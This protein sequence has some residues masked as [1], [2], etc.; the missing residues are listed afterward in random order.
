MN[1][2][3]RVLLLTMGIMLVLGGKP[4]K[5]NLQNQSPVI[6]PS[7]LAEFS[8][9]EQSRD[10]EEK[11]VTMEQIQNRCL[12]LHGADGV[13]LTV[14]DIVEFILGPGISYSNVSAQGIFG[15][16]SE[17][18][19]G[20]FSNGDCVPL[21]FDEG[22]ILSSG[23]LANVMG[24]NTSSETSA[25][26]GLPG[27]ADLNGLIPGYETYDASWI[28]FDF[29]PDDDQIYIQYVF[30]SEEYNQFVNSEYNDVF[31]FF[32]NGE[33]IALLPG[34]DIPVSINNV[35]NG[36]AVAGETAD[37]PC[38]NCEFYRDNADLSNPVF[39]IECDGMTTL[40]TATSEVTPG[41]TYTIKLAI[42]DAGD[43][44]LDSWVFIKAESFSTEEPAHANVITNDAEQVTNNEALLGGEVTY[45]GNLEV[46]GRGVWYGTSPDPAST[47]TKIPM[48]SGLGSFSD[49]VTNLHPN[50]HYYFIAYAVND[51]GTA[52]GEEK[53]FTTL[54]APPAVTT[55]EAS[56]I[57]FSSAIVGGEVTFD[58]GADVFERGFY[59]SD[60]PDPQSTGAKIY[61]GSG[62]GQFSSSLTNLIPA[63]T[64]YYVAFGTNMAGTE[65]GADKSF[66]TTEESVFVPNAIMPSSHIEETRV[67][68]PTFDVNPDIYSLEIFNQWGEKI[69]SSDDATIGWDGSLQNSKAKQGTYIYRVSYVD[70]RGEKKEMH[71]P[72]ILIR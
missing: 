29:I 56:E 2:F 39:D 40:L 43:D 12:S 6:N 51:E 54:A 37:G 71:G 25:S 38:T 4:G 10:V 61:E 57:D 22:V 14:E 5:T 17:A 63:T 53:E 23:T 35:N 26:L 28:E 1:K 34:S 49:T 9:I 62:T 55:G 13:Q 67:F 68:K 50:T 21:M 41:E 42:G 32:V 66:V 45:D 44:K 70:L 65:Y 72:F 59:F 47:G 24:P 16:A 15:D 58:G 19:I 69:F 8:V 52:F 36:H 20:V 30:G 33:N 27:D 11:R 18:S 31:G 46:T 48:G 60:T 7:G 3:Y 64:Y